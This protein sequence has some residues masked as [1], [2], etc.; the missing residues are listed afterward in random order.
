MQD[1]HS[2]KPATAENQTLKNKPAALNYPLVPLSATLEQFRWE[3]RVRFLPLP[4][5]QPWNSRPSPAWL[6][7]GFPSTKWDSWIRWPF[8]TFPNM[9][10]NY[11]SRLQTSVCILGGVGPEVICCQTLRRQFGW[12]E[13]LCTCAPNNPTF[14]WCGILSQSTFHWATVFHQKYSAPLKL[15]S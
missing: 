14:V 7:S 9:P 11:P 4:L 15:Q 12:V 6:S 10:A 8:Q 13:N 3:T 1:P 5:S 2:S